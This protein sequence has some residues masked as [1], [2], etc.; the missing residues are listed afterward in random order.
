STNLPSVVSGLVGKNLARVGWISAI[1]YA[2]GG[3]AMIL[4][5][6]HSDRT[7]ERRWHVAIPA[8][9][10]ATGLVI[11]ALSHSPV[12]ALAG[13]CLAALGQSS[14]LAPFWALSTSFLSGI[15]AAGAIAFI[16][17][18]G[19]LGGHFGPITMGWIKDR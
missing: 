9:I 14:T 19:N 5:G 16:N 10:G 4:I 3:I 15:A 8:F 13:L 1:P 18:V 2:C 7:R 6:L 17:S 11:T 12:P